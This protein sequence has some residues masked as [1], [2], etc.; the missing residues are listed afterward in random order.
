M[1]NQVLIAKNQQLKT[2]K[3]QFNIILLNNNL[4]ILLFIKLH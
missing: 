4:L 2:N 3:R 1:I